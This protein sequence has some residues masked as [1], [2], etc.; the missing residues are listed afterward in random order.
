MNAGTV[1]C[2]GGTRP[3]GAEEVLPL[4]ARQAK[5]PAQCLDD[6]LGGVRRAALFESGDVVDRDAGQLRELLAA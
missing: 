1:P 3:R 6:L 2:P 4:D 5:G